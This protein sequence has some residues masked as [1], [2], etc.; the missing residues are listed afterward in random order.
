[1]TDVKTLT[2][3]IG[4]IPLFH[5]IGDT[6]THS[7]GALATIFIIYATVDGVAD[8]LFGGAL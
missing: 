8:V 1:M 6:T 5:R 3:T 7:L 2:A 4:R